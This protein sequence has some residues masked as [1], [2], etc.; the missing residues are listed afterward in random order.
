MRGPEVS[1]FGSYA[2]FFD[3][4]RDLK[5]KMEVEEV[6]DDV[7]GA[8]YYLKMDPNRGLFNEDDDCE[9]IMKKKYDIY[10]IKPRPS[11]AISSAGLSKISRE[12][13]D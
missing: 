10:Q 6:N 13:I 9:E 7:V 3:R 4:L 11:D 1:S 12:E 5:A 2:K 8:D